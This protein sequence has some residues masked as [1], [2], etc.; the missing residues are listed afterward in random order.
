MNGYVHRVSPTCIRPC[1]LCV[2]LSVYLHAWRHEISTYLPA[3]AGAIRAGAEPATN[4]PDRELLEKFQL[5][6]FSL[7]SHSPGLVLQI[8]FAYGHWPL[9]S[10]RQMPFMM[11]YIVTLYMIYIYNYM[12]SLHKTPPLL[13]LY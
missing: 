5:Y 3:Q 9:T 8:V 7:P 1:S 2:F 13:H 10:I 6:C 11:L 12:R 4:Q